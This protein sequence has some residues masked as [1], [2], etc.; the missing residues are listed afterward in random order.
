MNLNDDNSLC[1]GD[2]MNDYDMFEECGI[3]VAMENGS[4]E[5]KRYANYIASSNDNDGVAEFIEDYLL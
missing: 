3:T 4:E 1:F 5:L 2:Q